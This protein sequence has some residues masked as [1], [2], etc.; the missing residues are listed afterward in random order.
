M[1]KETESDLELSLTVIKC[2]EL[3]PRYQ[4]LTVSVSV[5]IP[6]P[7]PM[8][9]RARAHTLANV[10]TPSFWTNSTQK[11]PHPGLEPELCA[12]YY[13]L[14]SLNLFI[15]YVFCVLFYFYS[16]RFY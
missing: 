4:N 12:K 1:Q 7:P 8:H 15:N 6:P 16:S 13:R 2:S 11:D 5:L 3:D 9:T 10:G 14:N